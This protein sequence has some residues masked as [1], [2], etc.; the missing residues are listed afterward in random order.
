VDAVRR[1]AGRGAIDGRGT[2]VEVTLGT[3]PAPVIVLVMA[4]VGVVLLGATT[5]AWWTGWHR[6]PFVLR[7]PPEY[8]RRA[9]SARRAAHRRVGTAQRVRRSELRAADRGVSSAERA[10]TRRIAA[11]EGQLR[12]LG[13]RRGRRLGDFGGCVLHEFVLI[14]P[15][16]EVPLDEVEAS[17]D[18]A[19]NLSVTKRATLTRMAA[20]GLLLGGLGA[21]LSLGFQKKEQQDTRELYLLLDAGPA[22]VVIQAVPDAGPEV[23]RFASQVNAAAFDVAARRARRQ[24]EFAAAR[25]E[26]A[27]VSADRSAIEDA[28]AHRDRV[29]AGTQAQV[30]LDAAEAALAD[31]R[32]REEAERQRWREQVDAI[33]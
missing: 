28:T 9:R 27:D 13:D 18:T 23:R 7:R 11:L 30:A 1:L 4:L 21:V 24:Q 32:A 17:V 8:V 20:G 22:S 2:R 25:D 26:H 3:G 16:G 29:L 12:E 33:R 15:G 5:W 19:G 14:T 6:L 10:R 31:A